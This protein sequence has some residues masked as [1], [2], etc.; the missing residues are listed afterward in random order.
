MKFR[1][2][3]WGE[4]LALP[5]REEEVDFEFCVGS[6]TIGEKLTAIFFSKM[7]KFDKKQKFLIQKPIEVY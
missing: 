4:C 6:A 5:R 2:Q 1:G 7:N 3:Y